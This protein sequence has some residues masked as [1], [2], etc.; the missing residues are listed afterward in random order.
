MK[1]KPKVLSYNEWRELPADKAADY[2]IGGASL[3]P[4]MADKLRIIIKKEWERNDTR[5][6]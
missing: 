6:I 3:P 4:G 2:V 5:K 1:R